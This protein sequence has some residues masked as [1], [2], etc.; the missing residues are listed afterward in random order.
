MDEAIDVLNRLSEADRK[1]VIY[2]FLYKFYNYDNNKASLDYYY[3]NKEKVLERMKNKRLQKKKEKAEKS[4]DSN[5]TIL[6]KKNKRTEWREKNKDRI[7]QQ[8]KEWRER[9]KADKAV[10]LVKEVDADKE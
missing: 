7:N 10:E 8:H 2:K 6:Y 1:S 9:K 3:K 4:V 5:E